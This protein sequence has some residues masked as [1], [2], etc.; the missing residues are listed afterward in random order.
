MLI[1]PPINIERVNGGSGNDIITG[2]SRANI[3]RGTLGD[4]I[5]D[6]GAASDTAS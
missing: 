3:L 6:G 5:I 4:E 1:D 2:D